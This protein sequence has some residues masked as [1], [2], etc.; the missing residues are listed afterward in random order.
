[1]C[2]R[3]IFFHKKNKI[4]PLFNM[5]SV[6][7]CSYKANVGAGAGAG[8]ETSWKSEPERKQKVS[9]P[10]HCFFLMLLPLWPS[11]LLSSILPL[12][13]E[14]LLNNRLKETFG[15]KLLTLLQPVGRGGGHNG[16]TRKHCLLGHRPRLRGGHQEN[17]IF[18][19][20]G[21][22]KHFFS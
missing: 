5:K 6:R 21:F 14:Q 16:R 15:W 22:F 8:A 20:H 19:R 9:A 3:L 10:Q 13:R 2:I 4:N 18:G 1:M 12:L 7:K 17:Y 11:P